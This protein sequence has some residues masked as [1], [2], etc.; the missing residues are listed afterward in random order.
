MRGLLYEDQALLIS[1]RYRDGLELRI[2]LGIGIEKELI[3]MKI[4]ERN[5][6]C[7]L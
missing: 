5:I 1:Q 4:R 7:N 2:E 3:E 6:E